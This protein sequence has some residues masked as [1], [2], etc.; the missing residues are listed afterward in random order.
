MASVIATKLIYV[1]VQTDR[2]RTE[3]VSGRELAVGF[4]GRE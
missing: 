2:E 3:G 4:N 1:G